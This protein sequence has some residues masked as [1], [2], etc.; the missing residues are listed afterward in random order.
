V[1]ITDLPWVR[2]WQRQCTAVREP[3]YD[4][5]PR[6]SHDYG[7][8]QLRRTHHGDHALRR[9]VDTPRWST[10]WVDGPLGAYEL[11]RRALRLADLWARFEPR[12]QHSIRFM[13]GDFASAV[14]HMCTLLAIQIGTE[15]DGQETTFDRIR[16][17]AE[18]ED[19]LR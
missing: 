8:C 19:T 4:V 6:T 12:E 3:R 16:R 5:R 15:G 7:R 14:D 2:V 11:H 18:A 9:G 13:A 10:D 17:A 1:T